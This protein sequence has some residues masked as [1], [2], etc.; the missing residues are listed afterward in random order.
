[1][2]H[3]YSD[4]KIG[5]LGGGQ[6]GRMLLQAAVDYNL[7]IHVLDP[8]ADAPCKKWGASFA[9]GSLTDYDTVYQFGKDMDLITIEI[10]NVNVEALKKLQEGGRTVFPE[11][12]VVYSGITLGV[13]GIFGCFPFDY[14]SN[15]WL[16]SGCIR[17][18]EKAIGYENGFYQ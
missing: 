16:Y 8:D 2:E 3:F 9:Q 1:M 10:E 15:I 5:M 7:E 11:P 17:P 4:Y 6:L 12:E 13:D 14:H 18:S